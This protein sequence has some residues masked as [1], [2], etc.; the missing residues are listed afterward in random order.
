MGS[1]CDS[2]CRCC[3]FVSVVCLYPVAILRAV[4]CVICSSCLMVVV[5]IWWKR[6]RVLVLLWIC[7]VR[8]SFPFVSPMLWF[9]CFEYLYCLACFCCGDLYVFVVCELGVKNQS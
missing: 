3:V 7:M 8:G 5:T 9:E 4:F 6:T 2:L 1:V